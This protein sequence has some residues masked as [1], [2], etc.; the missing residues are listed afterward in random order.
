M[1]GVTQQQPLHNTAV[2]RSDATRSQIG[3]GLK[4][5]ETGTW[6]IGESRSPARLNPVAGTAG[7]AR[8]VQ[9]SMEA[10]FSWVKF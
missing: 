4:D 5:A 2:L 3:A 9:Q 6:V 8:E 10:G 1:Q 7:N